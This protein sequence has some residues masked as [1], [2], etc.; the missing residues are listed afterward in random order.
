MSKYF[1]G[2]D[3]G[4]SSVRAFLVDFERKTSRAEQETYDVLIPSPG[5]AEHDVNIWWG[6]TCEALRRVLSGIDPKDVA[7]ISFSGQ[8]HG[9]VALD[10]AGMP[11]CNVAIWMDQRSE[12]AIK[13]IYEILGEDTVK[14]CGQNR[15]SPGFLIASLYWYK[16]RKPEIYRRIA[17][18]MLPKDY[19]KYRL[20]GRMCTDYS[21]AAGSLAFDNKRMD[22][23]EV[24]L[25]GLGID[26]ALFPEIVSSVDVIGAVTAEAARETGLAEGTPIVEGGSDQCMQSIGN[27]VVSEGTLAVNIGTSSLI[28]TPVTKP[29]YDEQLRTNT[30]AH[31]L[32]GYWSVVA[33]CLNGGSVLKWLTRTILQVDDYNEINRLVAQRGPASNG[34]IFMPYMAGERTPHMDPRARGVFFGLTMDHGRGDL[35]RAVMEGVV[36]GLKDGL[37]VLYDIGISC[38]RLVAAGGGARS[39][40]WLQMQADIFERD[41]YR[42]ASKEQACLGATITAAVGVGMFQNFEEACASCVE[43]SVQVFSPKDENVKVYRQIFDIYRDLYRDNKKTFARI[44]D[45]FAV[46]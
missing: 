23:S 16:T 5:Y 46:Q 35:A 3:L 32:P 42:S 44:G 43:P 41:V 30:F 9:L 19:I 24:M 8:M 15:I 17:H 7:G 33:A 14:E 13:E 1:I 28:S 25:N 20:S 11:V 22:W 27:A 36:F 29:Y 39:D 37:N 21:D 34:L 2:I 40:V 6:K 45:V 4:T 31:V 18:V 10:E 12:S 26:R 38:D